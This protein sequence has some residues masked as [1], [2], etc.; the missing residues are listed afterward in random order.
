MASLSGIPGN[1]HVRDFLVGPILLAAVLFCSSA[2]AQDSLAT[3]AEVRPQ[4]S[5]L[6]GGN[7]VALVRGA[8]L[9]EGQT[10]ITGAEG[11]VQVVF[12]DQTHLVIGR[13]SRLVIERY[14]MRGDGTPQ[15]FAINALAG[16]FRFIT[17]N[18]EK[19]AYN[20][21]TP[22][23]TMG[24]RGTEF[25]FTVQR[26]TGHTSVIVFEG[27]VKLCPTSGECVELSERCDV[28]QLVSRGE[29]ELVERE[30]DR[31][32]V[33]STAFP[34]LR[35]Q[36]RLLREFR[37]RTPQECAREI[38]QL[39]TADRKPEV[40]APPPPPPPPPPPAGGEPDPP[41]KNNKGGGNGGETLDEGTTE[42]ENP[43]KHLGQKKKSN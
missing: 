17:G 28:G 32:E 16:S 11:E 33:A 35:S 22:T 41:A 21:A 27:G 5:A 37:V 3:V 42:G 40:L 39:R 6:L 13:G 9:R 29:A 19:S 2:T 20:I 24:I 26:G 25:D 15:K 14:L 18:G 38:Q 36:S 8:D 43:G 12:S 30:A 10:V 34:Y 4:A 23:G 1:D 7:Q 31:V